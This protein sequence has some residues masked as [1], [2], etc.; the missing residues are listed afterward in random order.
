MIALLSKAI[1]LWFCVLGLAHAQVPGNVVRRT[2][3]GPGMSDVE[4]R[5][6]I[7]R[8][9]HDARIQSRDTV[10]SMNRTYFAKSWVG[11]TLF[12]YDDG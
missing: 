6:S 8:A 11:A 4:V 9:L 10:Y 12:Q 1:S 7:G 2:R 3:I 5:H